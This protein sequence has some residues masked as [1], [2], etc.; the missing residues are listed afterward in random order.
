MKDTILKTHNLSKKYGTEMAVNNVNMTINKGDIYGFIGRNG[1]GKTTLIRMITGLISISSGEME[2]LGAS[3]PNQLKDFYCTMHSSY[4]HRHNNC[5]YIKNNVLRRCYTKQPT[6]D[7]K[8]ATGSND[9][10]PETRQ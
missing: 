3:S 7:V 8:T 10:P 5:R 9:R 6:G 2:L 4:S 1:A